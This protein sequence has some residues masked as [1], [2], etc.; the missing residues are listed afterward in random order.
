MTLHLAISTM[1][2]VFTRAEFHPDGYALARD[3]S[4][5]AHFKATSSEVLFSF[6]G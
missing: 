4:N 6:K 5:Y 3:S 1:Q 2:Q